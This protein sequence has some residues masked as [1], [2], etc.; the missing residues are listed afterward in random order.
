MVRALFLRSRGNHR[1]RAAFPPDDHRRG[2][3]TLGRRRATRRRRRALPRA[4][5]PSPE[6]AMRALHVVTHGGAMHRQSASSSATAPSRRASLRMTSSIRLFGHEAPAV[7]PRRGGPEET[8]LWFQS[9]RA[10]VGRSAGSNA[11][12][13][14]WMRS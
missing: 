8:S 4:R 11:R 10:D 7:T 9:R 12:R 5:V 13:S 3:S 1:S 6:V 14:A 2:L